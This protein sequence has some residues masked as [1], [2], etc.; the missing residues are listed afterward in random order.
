MKVL[1]ELTE[2]YFGL[3][4]LKRSFIHT[5]GSVGSDEESVV[6]YVKIELLDRLETLRNGVGTNHCFGG[7]RIV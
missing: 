6:F 1:L 4:L 7:K 3:A 5:S 2:G